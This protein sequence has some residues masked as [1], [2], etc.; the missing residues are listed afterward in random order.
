MFQQMCSEIPG[1]K[2][3]QILKTAA[4]VMDG[5]TDLTKQKVTLQNFLCE[6][7]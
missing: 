5:R 2:L 7:A 3:K 6:Y 4:E 1:I